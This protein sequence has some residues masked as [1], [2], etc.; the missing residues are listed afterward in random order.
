ML[1]V[2]G[3]GVAGVGVL[4][5]SIGARVTLGIVAAGLA[6]AAGYLLSGEHRG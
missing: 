5:A 4:L 2:A 3:V 1:G 6:L